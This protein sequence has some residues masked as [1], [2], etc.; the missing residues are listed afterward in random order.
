[1]LD[2]ELGF[3]VAIAASVSAIVFRSMFSHS[4]ILAVLPDGSGVVE[5]AVYLKVLSLL[6]NYKC[7]AC[8]ELL[9]GHGG[10]NPFSF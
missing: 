3:I 5:S 2:E 10:P 1:M 4:S 9:K 6:Y 7:I 8:V